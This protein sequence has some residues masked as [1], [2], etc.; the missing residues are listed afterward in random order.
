MATKRSKVKETIKAWLV[1][2]EVKPHQKIK[3][4]HELA[5]FFQVSRHTIRQ[6]IGDLVHEGW[7]YR[8]QGRGTFYNGFPEK[9]SN[10]MIGI[11]TTY[12][13]DYI[14]PSIIRGAESYLNTKGYSILLASTNN[15]PEDEKEC[16]QMML[17]KHVDGLILEPT[18]TALYNENLDYYLTLEQKRIPYIMINAYYPNLQ[19]PSLTMDDELGGYLAAKHLIELGHRRIAGLFKTDDLQGINRMKGFFRAHREAA[20]SVH[21]GMI[22][23][24]VTE[25][26]EEK[27]RAAFQRLMRSEDRP[28]A[29]FCYN[30]EIA[31]AILDVIRGMGLKVP[32][33]ISVVGYD[34][35]HLAEASEV[36]LTTVKHPKTQMGEMAAKLLIEAVEKRN[37]GHIIESVVFQ[38]ELIVRSSTGKWEDDG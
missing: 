33:D 19:P 16:L 26:K 37:Q 9:K 10:K 24:Y 27:P 13:S 3:S 5:D 30:D 12:I 35:S 22:V 21:P 32:R 29:V 15:R 25:E 7:L 14:F 34:D 17:D 6:A 28:T 38:P 23:S 11:I 18:K 20:L 36:K 4:E 1:N 31:L 2:G 8:E